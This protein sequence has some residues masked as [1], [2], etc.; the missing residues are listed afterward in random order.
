[1]G[2]YEVER[3]LNHFELN[4][5]ARGPGSISPAPGRIFYPSNEVVVLT[6]IPDEDYELSGWTGDA[7]RQENP[8]SI[9]MDKDQSI[10]ADFRYAPA[11][12][13][14]LSG[15]TN[16]VLNKNS[17]GLGSLRQAVRN[18]NASGGGTIRFSNVI[19]VISL[20]MGLPSLSSD[21]R[22]VGPGPSNLL[23][24]IPTGA[25]GF[26]LDT[27]VTGFISGI[28]IQS[29]QSTN[30]LGGAISNSGILS[31]RDVHFVNSSSSRGG[32][33][34]NNGHLLASGC[35]FSNNSATAG[36]AIYNRGILQVLSSILVTNQS[37]ARFVNYRTDGGGGAFYNESGDANYSLCEFLRNN[38]LGLSG[39]GA[40]VDDLATASGLGGAINI[41]GGHV[42][43]FET[44]IS[45]NS[46]KGQNG[47]G[48]EVGH[49]SG[50]GGSALGSGIYIS[51][52]T[53]ALT[54]SS[55]LSNLGVAGD[56]P[57]ASRYPGGGGVASGGGIYL[58]SGSLFAVNCTFSGNE[59]RSGNSGGGG[60]FMACGGGG[61][62]SGGAL[63]VYQGTGVLA[64]CTITANR[65]LGGDSKGFCG[66]N[67]GLGK[68]G[69]ITSTPFG[70]YSSYWS[71]GSVLLVNTIVAGNQGSTNGTVGIVAGDLNGPGFSLGHN[72]IGTPGAF[73]NLLSSDLVGANPRLGPLQGN[74]GPTL[75]HALLAN[76]P[77]IDAG[78]TGI[79]AVDQR[80]Q[81]RSIDVPAIP[82]GAGSGGTDIGAT[83]VDPTL[84]ITGFSKS[85]DNVHIGFTTVSDKTYRLQHRSEVA[86]PP[87]TTFQLAIAG[88]GGIVTVTNREIGSSKRLFFRAI[89][90]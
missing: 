1:M 38:A 40:S 51:D 46:T 66:T 87:W 17:W 43:F 64:N 77:G 82:N 3:P 42:G 49:F 16:Y 58:N 9:R 53:L 30:R 10:R 88:S 71:T 25:D 12:V 68:G 70:D 36:G 22:I 54:N 7:M 84:R 61:T 80:G 79:L 76:S 86:E 11:T 19:G 73:T 50:N 89:Q 24:H 65:A 29:A 59:V 26:S 34:F 27:G 44:S 55:L 72:L 5:V 45:G 75:S 8:L 81:P 20:A 15:G 78:A 48:Y 35:V 14:N 52:G 62:G 63:S 28:T 31:I 85:G 56:S 33:V 6:A 21:V 2:A 39:G 67:Y 23:V 4:L 74:G 83:E 13:T 18:I 32:A 41:A 37:V 60:Y 69:G 90:Q 57:Y 47:L